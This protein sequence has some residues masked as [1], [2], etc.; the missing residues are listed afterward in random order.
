MRRLL[1][2]VVLLGAIEGCSSFSETGASDAGLA[3]E[4]DAGPDGAVSDGATLDAP[5][6]AD[7]GV[8]EGVP[9]GG[10]LVFL[11]TTTSHPPGPTGTFVAFADAACKDEAS[12]A[13]RAGNYVA[14]LATAA[15]SAISR[16]P[17]DKT[18]YL[19]NGVKIGDFQVFNNGAIPF[20]IDRDAMARGPEGAEH[21]VWTGTLIGGA[22][23]ADTCTNWT[24]PTSGMVGDYTQSGTKWASNGTRPCNQDARFYCF[25]K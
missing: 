1:A 11:S 2:V 21:A 14:W 25:E 18:W 9:P 17:T 7:S 15:Q 19:R 24:L 12:A 8:V 3:S 5:P 16:L 10:K 22:T 13:G 6:P 4:L 20:A 23:A